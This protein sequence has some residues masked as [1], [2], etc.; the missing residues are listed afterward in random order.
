MNVNLTLVIQGLNFFCAYYLIRRFLLK[1]VVAM[2]NQDHAQ[3]IALESAIAARKEKVKEQERMLYDYWQQFLAT[4]KHKMLSVQ[5][6]TFLKGIKP[7][8]ENTPRSYESIKMLTTD[9]VN[10]SIKKV[11]D[12]RW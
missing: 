3:Q 5:E 2:I 8:L 10:A 12:V 1:P 7:S 4:H 6:G 9:L 11:S